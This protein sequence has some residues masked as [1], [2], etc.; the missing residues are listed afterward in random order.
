VSFAPTVGQI[1]EQVMQKLRLDPADDPLALYWINQAYVD[2]AQYTGFY[3]ANTTISPTVA[4]STISLPDAVK[5][6]RQV[7]RCYQNAPDS[8]PAQKVRM[9]QV[10]ARLNGDDTPTGRYDT[11]GI[12]AVS[13]EYPNEI[14]IWPVCAIGETIVVTYSKL[15]QQVHDTDKPLISEPFGSKILEYGALV[16]G[17]KFKKDPLLYDFEN[18]HALWVDRYVSWLNRRKTSNSTAFEIWAGGNDVD[19][20]EAESEHWR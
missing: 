16:E 9:E 5:Q 7:Q 2:I 4:S 17:A 14:V 1:K 18:T 20:L 12:Y 3:V 15:P 19:R 6:I 11:G 10:L 13:G 8:Y